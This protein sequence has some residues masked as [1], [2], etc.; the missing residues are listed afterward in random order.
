MDAVQESQHIFRNDKTRLRGQLRIDMPSR[1]G[2]RHMI[3]A[4][5]D[6]L[7]QHRDLRVGNL[8]D[9]NI[10]CRKLGDVELLTC[11]SP[12]YFKTRGVREQADYLSGEVMVN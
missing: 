4:L 7:R 11:G 1:I 10:I 2:R 9:T 12:D 5:P 3:E 6:F 8:R